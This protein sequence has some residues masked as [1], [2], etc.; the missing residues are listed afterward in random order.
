MNLYKNIK[1]K[2]QKKIISYFSDQ[3]KV[4]K[5]IMDISDKKIVSTN[6]CFDLLHCGHIY[7]FAKAKEFGDVLIVGLNSDKSVK[8]LKGKNR[9]IRSE[10]DRAI[11][12]AS[13]KY[14]DYVIIFNDATPEKFLKKVKPSIH[15]K[16]GDYSKVEQLPEYDIIRKIGGE[17]KIIKLFDGK[18][19]TSEL[20]K[21]SNLLI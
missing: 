15:C 12:L 9:P 11:M 10:I 6:G 16:G 19:T 8:K 5:I 20:Y 4:N 18:S 1:I 13:I 2:D 21:I 7:S 17:I 3:K 14:I